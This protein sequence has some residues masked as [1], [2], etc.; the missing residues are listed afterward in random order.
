MAS[1]L[2]LPSAADI[3]TI[4]D[5]LGALVKYQSGNIGLNA[6]GESGTLAMYAAT[7]KNKIEGDG[8]AYYGLANQ[9]LKQQLTP[10][11]VSLAQSLRYDSLFAA[12]VRGIMTALDNWVFQNLPNG[13]S[14]AQTGGTR[15][16]DL[17]QQRYNANG[18]SVPATPGYTP[19]LTATTG[20]ALPAVASGNGPRLK[21]AYVSTGGDW[22]ESQPSQN[23]AQT[24]LTGNNNAYTVGSLPGSVPTGVGKL[25]LYRQLY[26]NG[27]SSDPYYWAGDVAV[28]AGSAFPTVTLKQAD[29]ALR[30]D[31]TPASW[32]SCLL[33]PE[34]AALYALAFASPP[35]QQGALSTFL[36]FLASSFAS[37][38][39]VALNPVSG[40]LGI[41]NPASTGQL[42]QW[43]SGTFTAGVIQTANDPLNVIQGFAGAANSVQARVTATLSANATVS[44]IGYTYVNA[45]NPST[46]QSGTI[47]GP[48]TLNSVIGDTVDLAVPAGNLVTAITGVTVGTATTGTIIFEAD[49]LRSI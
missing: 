48:L 38:T 40:F 13:W 30:L 23:S 49:A 31:V 22:I 42:G 17:W 46:P 35:Q 1:T 16:L 36:S 3:Q 5:G 12:N 47:A 11:M 9:N 21:V 45:A 34:E 27:G 24:A 33:L 25:R 10:L 37:V 14:F 39:N 26:N 20:G 43:S 4:M 19:T 6:P 2:G 28:T 32:L 8:G 18:A 44:S 41:N 15:A 29:Q 7:A